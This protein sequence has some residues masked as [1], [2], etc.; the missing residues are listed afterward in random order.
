MYIMEQKRHAQTTKPIQQ[1]Y[2]KFSD[3]LSR[4]NEKPQPPL[5]WLK[6]KMP[7]KRGAPGTTPRPFVIINRAKQAYSQDPIMSTIFLYSVA[8]KRALIN[9]PPDPTQAQQ[10][11]TQLCFKLLNILEIQRADVNNVVRY[12]LAPE[13]VNA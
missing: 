6:N 4:N 1:T 2:R 10:Q 12:L 8:M 11:I 7:N 5:E 9:L 3:F 13:S